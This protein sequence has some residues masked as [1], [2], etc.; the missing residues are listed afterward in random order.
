MDAVNDQTQQAFTV[1]Q[2]KYIG[3]EEVEEEV[4]EAEEE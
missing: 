4:E 3:E 2:P 1:H